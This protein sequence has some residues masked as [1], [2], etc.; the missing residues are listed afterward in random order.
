M[1][2]NDVLNE[3]ETAQTRW[4]LIINGKPA[5]HYPSKNEA[6]EIKRELT[7]KLG[8]DYKI[9]IKSITTDELKKKKIEEAM[10]PSNRDNSGYW[11]TR[12]VLYVDDNNKWKAVAHYRTEESAEEVGKEY[13]KQHGGKYK[14]EMQDVP[15][16]KYSEDRNV[17]R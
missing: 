12:W 17:S 10:H 15:K 8:S 14:V 16:T 3:N 13:T 4:L 9:E 5:A 6:A 11:V 2:I 1:R 7:L